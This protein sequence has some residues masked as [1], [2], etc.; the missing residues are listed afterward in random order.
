MKKGAKQQN[1]KK[2]TSVKKL[3]SKVYKE[4]SIKEEQFLY[5]ILWLYAAKSL[6]HFALT[7]SCRWKTNAEASSCLL[8]ADCLQQKL[9]GSPKT[10]TQL[11]AGS[12]DPNRTRTWTHRPLCRCKRPSEWSD[13]D[14]VFCRTGSTCSLKVL[15]NTVNMG[16][17][18]ERKI[19][20]H[21]I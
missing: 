3:K 6:H 16:R 4:K 13:S 20:I 18:S 9:Q 15:I 14:L 1:E 21:Q 17:E 19:W 7:A 5:F 8:S 11:K 10:S 12:A 2:K